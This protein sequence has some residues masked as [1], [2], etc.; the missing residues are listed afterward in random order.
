MLTQAKAL[1]AGAQILSIST[2]ESNTTDRA[3]SSLKMDRVHPRV[4]WVS[5]GNSLVRFAP[6][7]QPISKKCEKFVMA[8]KPSVTNQIANIERS[9]RN[10]AIFFSTA[11]S[12]R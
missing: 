2:N 4:F 1:K 8:F 11:Q 10:G 9:F 3:G 7:R 5:F 6:P 12:H